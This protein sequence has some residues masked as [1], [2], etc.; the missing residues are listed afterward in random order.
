[1]RGHR[2]DKGSH[3]PFLRNHASPFPTKAHRAAVS[4][5]AL[6]I[7][8]RHDVVEQDDLA[9]DALTRSL[10]LVL[11]A[12][13]DHRCGHPV[14]RR[15]NGTAQPQHGERLQAWF[16]HHRG[17]PAANPVRNLDR[18]QTNV[19]LTITAHRFCRPH[20][21]P[22]ELRRTAKPM[23][24]I[25]AKLLHLGESVVACHRRGHDPIGSHAIA[26]GDGMVGGL[27]RLRLVWFICDGG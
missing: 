21:R 1:M 11:V 23:T 16:D 18:F 7:V 10:E 17:L 9:A 12:N 26:I 3:A 14:G 6:R 25:V 8:G 4:R 15:P 27:A 13:D 20:N 19:L 5:S 22:F 2:A 24:D